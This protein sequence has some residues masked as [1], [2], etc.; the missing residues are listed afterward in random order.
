MSL[1][2]ALRI[3]GS[4]LAAV[5][6]GLAQASQ[7]VANAETE[8][9]TRKSVPQ[10]SVTIGPDPAGVRSGEAARAVDTALLARLDASR[11]S[12]AAAAQREALLTGI[13]QAHGDSGETLADG[14]SDLRN[15]FTALRAAPADAGE[16]QAAVS[17]ARTLAERLNTLSQAIT[18][19]RQQAQDDIVQQ[20][21]TANAA[22]R[23]VAALTERIRN[24]ADGDTAT[25]EDRRDAA[26]ATLSES[27][28]VQAVKREGGDVLL[29][30]KGGVVLP[31]DPDRDL[32]ATSGATVQPGSLH[33][34]SGTLPGVTLN[35]LDVTAQLTGGR[36]G[37]D[38]A[39][40]DT[41][42]PRYQAEADLLAANLAAR[43]DGQ[44]LR[45]FTDSNGSSVPD[46]AQAYAGSSQVG[47][48]GRIRVN[49]AVT[50]NPALLRDGTH[51]VTG[52]ATG[53][54]AFTPNPTGGPAGFTTLL[55]RVLDY[56]F[57]AEA[58]AGKPWPAIATTG[59]GPDGSLAS[60][61]A[62]PATLLDYAA[63]VTAAQTGDRATATAA[64][65]Q[66][67]ALQ[68][69]LETRFAAQSGVNRDTEMANIV[70]LQNAYA[71]NAKVLSTVQALFDTLLAAV[72]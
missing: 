72:R 43:L 15:A 62:A 28:G 7:N 53:P 22:L 17:V 51:A 6:R 50:A 65:E 64:K 59:L 56:G 19:A 2:A 25:L 31:L 10:R 5:Q 36:L 30:A 3:A 16:Q 61:F 49:P 45:L 23:Q 52:S 63:R 14:L 41:T 44:G 40:R 37:E 29:V 11:A 18:D 24:G 69:S 57:G 55:D 21:K 33:G 66:S 34:A 1:D 12:S 38:L 20:V 9:Y 39:L 58:A 35:G 54:S 32:L 68:T 4:G 47:F 67:Q 70:S 71:A 26:I 8:G 60:P 27:L 13:E 48:A 42:L 46:T